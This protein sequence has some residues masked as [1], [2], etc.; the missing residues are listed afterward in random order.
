[1]KPSAALV[2]ANP[3]MLGR[4]KRCD[5][6]NAGTSGWSSVVAEHHGPAWETPTT[7]LVCAGE[8]PVGK[9]QGH[10]PSR[11]GF[12]KGGDRSGWAGTGRLYLKVSIE[13]EIGYRMA[14]EPPKG[15]AGAKANVDI[16]AGINCQWTYVPQPD[17]PVTS[18]KPCSSG[19]P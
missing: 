2:Q 13:L 16:A 9:I 7:T 3:K 11:N 8:L 19:R 10:M 15:R 1:M 18:L 12:V 4:V 5:P 14:G 6:L 17:S